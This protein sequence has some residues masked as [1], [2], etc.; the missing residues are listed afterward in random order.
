MHTPLD[1]HDD[2][3]VS[4]NQSVLPVGRFSRPIGLVSIR[5][6]GKTLEFPGC[7][8]L[9]YFLLKVA[10]FWAGFWEV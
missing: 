4:N 3:V 6:C 1:V 7:G 10:G 5:S 8:Y 9:G 2:L